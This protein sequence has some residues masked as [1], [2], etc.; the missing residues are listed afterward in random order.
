[1]EEFEVALRWGVKKGYEAVATC[2]SKNVD[3]K[4]RRVTL[5]H[6]VALFGHEPTSWGS[7]RME[8]CD[9]VSNPNASCLPRFER[10]SQSTQQ[11]CG[12]TFPAKSEFH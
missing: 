12:T 9:A 4:T 8:Q 10:L 3:Q 7:Q 11:H 6:R 1:M 2:F 5:L